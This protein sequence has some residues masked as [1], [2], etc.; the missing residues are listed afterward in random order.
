MISGPNRWGVAA[1]LALVLTLSACI[2]EDGLP[3][4]GASKVSAQEADC[5]A[6]GGRWGEAG[7]TGLMICYRATRDGNQACRVSGDCQGFCLARS[8]TCAP[9]TPLLGC[10]DVLGEAGEESTVCV[11]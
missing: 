2:E 8:R 11:Q 1:A 6:D 5:V 3:P 7:T 10:N 4:A 9:F